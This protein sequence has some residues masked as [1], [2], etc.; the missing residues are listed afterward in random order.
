M[1]ETFLSNYPEKPLGSD[2]S[3]VSGVQKSPSNEHETIM[4]REK[5][6]HFLIVLVESELIYE[7]LN[8][9]IHFQNAKRAGPTSRVD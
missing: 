1:D 9:G 4:E 3:R 2:Q 6:A 7:K 5:C 8:L